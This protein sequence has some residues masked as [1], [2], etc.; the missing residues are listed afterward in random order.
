MKGQKLR[1]RAALPEDGD[2]LE[3]FFAE[4][5]IGAPAG[6]V[7]QLIG[8]LA[9]SV[10]AHAS[11]RPAGEALELEHLLV[12]AR[13]RRLRIGRAFV[14]EIEKLAAAMHYRSLV[15]AADCPVAGYLKARGFLLREGLLQK[16]LETLRPGG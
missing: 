1:V 12:A 11:A 3:A 13:L 5:T 14:S 9:G 8:R 7:L 10:V 15:A 4:E 16:E 6:D 2:E